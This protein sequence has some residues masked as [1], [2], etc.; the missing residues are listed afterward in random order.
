MSVPVHRAANPKRALGLGA[1]V[2]RA[3]LATSSKV[4]VIAAWACVVGLIL[5]AG[6][7]ISGFY[8][9]AAIRSELVLASLLGIAAAGQT[10]VVILGGIDLSIP[11][12]MTLTAVG[13]SQLSYDH[14]STA[15]ALVVLA[16]LCVMIGALNGLLSQLLRVHPLVVTLG[17]NFM[18]SGALLAWTKGNPQG[19]PPAFINSAAAASSSMGPIPLPPIVAV[20]LV[21][22]IVVV[23]IS[24][25]TQV[26]R[27]MYAYGASPSAAGYA[28]VRPR[29]LWM[30]VF[31]LSG[32]TAFVAGTMLA[33][34]TGYGDLSVGDPYLF[35]TVAA[36]VLGGTSLLGGRGS[37][38][39][40]IAG[41][42]SLTLAELVLV[43]NGVGS[44]VQQVA[45]GVIIVGFLALYGR[46]PRVRDRV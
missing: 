13:I 37:Y 1:R 27:R 2:R 34:F 19:S 30:I 17:T 43:G 40:T 22:A 41:T 25:R 15:A 7:S 5:V 18:V 11:A 28:L 16:I 23:V 6:V 8:T 39:R 26:G 29:R 38:V 9:L 10:L 45:L 24:T 46:E 42:L 31:G 20:W 3:R 36:V 21:V 35:N 44:S 12:L 4:P 33:G 32:L 14:W